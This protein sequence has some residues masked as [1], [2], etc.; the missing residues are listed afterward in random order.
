MRFLHQRN[1]VNWYFIFCISQP[2]TSMSLSGIFPANVIYQ[3]VSWHPI[4]NSIKSQ[5]FIHVVYCH[6]SCPFEAESSSSNVSPCSENWQQDTDPVGAW[7]SFTKPVWGVSQLVCALFPLSVIQSV[8]PVWVQCPLPN[9]CAM[10]WL[11]ASAAGW[12][13][14]CDRLLCFCAWTQIIWGLVITGPLLSIPLSA[15]RNISRAQVL[16]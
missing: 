14:L 5:D 8:P 15:D 9:Y 1:K 16:G 2:Q 13:I 7:A 4:K 3:H 10:L 6:L 12:L 11:C